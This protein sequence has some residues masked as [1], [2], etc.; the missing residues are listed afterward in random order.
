MCSTDARAR[1]PGMV[2][3][4]GRQGTVA[5]TRSPGHGRQDTVARAR[6]PRHGCQDTVARTRSPG[7]GCQDTVARTRSPG[8]G[9]QGTVLGGIG[10]QRLGALR[11]LCPALDTEDQLATGYLARFGHKGPTR[12]W[13]LDITNDH[14]TL[15]TLRTNPPPDIGTLWTQRTNPPMST[16]R[17]Q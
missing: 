1:S 10:C 3:G 2:V 13:P 5:R 16:G 14:G 12:Q 6:S 9:R 17:Y 15:W 7:H 4:P 11:F 8:H